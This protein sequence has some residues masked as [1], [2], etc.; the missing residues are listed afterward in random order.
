[1]QSGS[2]MKQV[3]STFQRKGAG[4]PIRRHVKMPFGRCIGE[5]GMARGRAVEV[6]VPE[7]DLAVCAA[8]RK[9]CAPSTVRIPISPTESHCSH[10]TLCTG[11]CALPI[12]V[13]MRG[14]P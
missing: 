3:R 6:G 5:S 1:M 11:I 7:E 8:G 9:L 2:K 12:K 4:R 14:N 10:G 13:C